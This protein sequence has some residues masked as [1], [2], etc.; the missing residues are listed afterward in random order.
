MSKLALFLPLSLLLVACAGSSGYMKP[1]GMRPTEPPPGMALVYIL[2]PT[3]FFGVGSDFQVWDGNN[4]IG[5]A[6]ANKCFAYTCAPGRHFFM[7]IAE[8]NVGIDADL[9]A[10]PD[11]R[12]TAHRST[13]PVADRQAGER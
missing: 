5:V 6:L 1:G 3:G 8:N 9:S 12:G 2:R 13:G 11:L 10:G 4:C 7:F